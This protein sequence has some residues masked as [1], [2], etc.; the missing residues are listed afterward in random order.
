MLKDLFIWIARVGA[1]PAD[2]DDIALKK[3]LLM[4]CSLPFAIASF[5]WGIMYY[6]F[7][8]PLA[9]AIPFIYGII[10]LLSILHFGLTHRFQFFRFS[11]LTLILMLPF[12]LMQAL[13]GYISGSAVI[14][15]AVICPLGAMLFDEPRRALHWFSA[16]LALVV[17]S[18][19]LEFKIDTTNNLSPDLVIFFFALNL[20]GIGSIIF[21]MVFYFVSQKNQF[22]EKA[23][24]LLLNILPKAIVATLKDEHQT[25]ADHYEASSILF[26]DIVGSTPLFAEMRPADVVDW[27]NEVFSMFDQLVEKYG[28]EKI[29]TIGD[30]YMVA[31]GVPTPREDHA[32]A[33]TSLA[34]EILNGLEDLP[35]GN[36]KRLDFRLGINSGPVV[37]GVIGKSKFQYD[38]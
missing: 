10:S 38:V 13:G 29:R 11:Q 35:E 5:A 15:W 9:A 30:N 22:Q 34:L 23:D 20:A 32:Q 36:G 33:I 7:D 12:L 16:F 17:L 14:M 21:I 28:V 24:S 1:N 27:L 6:N 4:V 37:A 2:E 26:C 18:G 25:V 3:S 19:F 31:S 8:E